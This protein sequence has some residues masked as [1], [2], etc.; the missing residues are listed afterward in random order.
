MNI[1]LTVKIQFIGKFRTSLMPSKYTKDQRTVAM[2]E[3]IATNKKK[4]V[5]PIHAG[6]AQ[7]MQI[8]PNICKV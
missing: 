4:C 2:N 1:I 5:A 8:I 6:D 7:A 3:V